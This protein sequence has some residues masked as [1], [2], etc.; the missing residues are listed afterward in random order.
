MRLAIKRYNFNTFKRD[1]RMKRLSIS[2]I[3]CT[4][5]RIDCIG[6]CLVSIAQQVSL[7][8]ELV[9]VDSSDTPLMA[10]T[11]FAE[12]FHEEKFPQTRLKYRHSS[13]GLTHQRNVGINMVT[14]S[15]I[16]FFDDDVILDPHYI[17][18]MQRIFAG[19][20]EYAGGMGT[21][22]NLGSISKVHYALRRFFLAHRNY[23]TGM[24]TC[25]G[26][27]THTYGTHTF[28]PVEALGGCC[29]AYRSYVFENEKFD[30][31]LK[32]Y[33]FM[34]DCDFSKRVSRNFRLFYNPYARLVHLQSPMSREKLLDFRTMY[35]HYYTYLFFK[36]FYS[37]NRLR[38][39][40]YLWTM[41][42]LLLDSCAQTITKKNFAYIRGYYRG[43][44]TYLTES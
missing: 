27:P 19:H 35:I 15:V 13:P 11:S 44:R 9:I 12:I 39:V 18:Q 32:R 43:L 31:N 8:D 6:D 41:L 34:E 25:S 30:E 14:G 40:A 1:I 36:N 37:E 10:A 2:V 22:T 16:Y 38:I 3:I 29:C 26:M 28:K 23:S 33:A 5:N 17:K 21:I 20:P 4:R 42:G 24:F 7:P